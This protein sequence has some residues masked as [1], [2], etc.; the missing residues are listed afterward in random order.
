[1]KTL[2]F[3]H[4]EVD[5][6][7]CNRLVWLL[8]CQL[9]GTSLADS[10][11]TTMN[12]LYIAYPA[13]LGG[14][15]GACL[16]AS[17][18]IWQLDAP[19]KFQMSAITDAMIS[20]LTQT[21]VRLLAPLSAAV[22]V[23]IIV[24]LL[25]LLYTIYQVGAVFD[26]SVY[27]LS[28]MVLMLPSMLLAVLFSAAVYQFT[29][30]A[31]LSLTAF[32]VFAALSL[33]V[34]KDNW[35][36]CWLNPILFAL[37]DDFSNIRLFR[38]IGYARLT[39]LLALSGIYAV[40]HLCVRQ[41]GK[42]IV[43]SFSV[44][45]QQ[46]YHP[47]IAVLLLFSAEIFYARQP[48]YDNSSPDLSCH[49]LDAEYDPELTCS[50]LYADVHPNAKTGFVSGKVVYKLQNAS[51]QEKTLEF[52]IDPG[53]SISSLLVNNYKA[54]YTH[55]DIQ[56]TGGQVVT[57]AL[58][59]D[60]KVEL[61]VVYDRFPREWNLCVYN[62]GEPEIS[63]T[64]MRMENWLIFPTLRNVLTSGGLDSTLDYY[65]AFPNATCSVR[66]RNRKASLC[67]RRRH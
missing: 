41:Y 50:K 5:R 58:P 13:L 21:L 47:V 10:I 37:S 46:V 53:Y 1:M 4:L 33:T 52:V 48:F 27:L 61:E 59:S 23:Q 6:L 11:N 22:M 31:D 62:P 25:W 63:D 35:Q 36:L 9:M 14:L 43:G 40:S 60:H 67:Q 8:L 2:R 16:L 29:Q 45:V 18:T 32:L 30:R 66:H 28:Y 15:V 39:R 34:W 42:G 3:Y 49:V 26:L 38:T 56:M 20:P 7:F 65:F 19:H 17:L 64:Y 54:E 44:S 51:G 12:N 55:T 57:V 24:L